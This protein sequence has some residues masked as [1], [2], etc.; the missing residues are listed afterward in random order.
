M[1]KEQ[2]DEFHYHEMVDRLYFISTMISEMIEQHPVYEEHSDLRD[3]VDDAQSKLVDAYQ[4]ASGIA[5][6]KFRKE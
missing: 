2:L 5:Y 3:L 4:L 1:S 6:K